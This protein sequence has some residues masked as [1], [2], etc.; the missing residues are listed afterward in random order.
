[1]KYLEVA[2]VDYGMGNIR[3]VTSA[4][5]YL[6][7]KTKLI[8]DP[9]EISR[10]PVLVLPGVGS[11]KSG[12]KAL[13][14]SGANEAIVDAVA[15][16]GSKLLGICLGMQLMGSYSSEEGGSDGLGLLPNSVQ[17]F[18]CRQEFEGKVPHVGFNAIYPDKRKG[19]F[20]DLPKSPEFYF[21]HSYYMEQGNLQ[22]NYAICRYGFEFLSAYEI[23]NICGVQFHPEK[24]QV[25]GLI[26]LKNFM[27]K[28]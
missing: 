20:K 19:I 13:K 4:F 3:S 12:M 26:L 1:V 27:E 7:I 28:S 5:Q 8:S 14:K 9:E 25:N 24:S 16:N 15:N 18:Q 23:D 11:F 21:T 22:G 2:I 6:G 10:S 17:G